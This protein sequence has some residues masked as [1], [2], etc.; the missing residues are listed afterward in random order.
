M[1]SVTPTGFP[2]RHLSAVHELNSARNIDV[3]SLT[4]ARSCSQ[5]TFNETKDGHGHAAPAAQTYMHIKLLHLIS[6]CSSTRRP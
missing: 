1:P 3:H 4:Q 2:Y 6:R 5:P